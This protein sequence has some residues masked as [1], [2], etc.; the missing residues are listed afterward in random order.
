[1]GPVGF[2]AVSA[3]LAVASYNEQK[4]AAKAQQRAQKAKERMAAAQN[5]REKR[6]QLREARRQ[7]EMIAAEQAS[8]GTGAAAV[9]G[10]SSQAAGATVQ[11]ELGANL[12]F[13]DTMT[14]LNQYASEQEIYAS[15]K[16]TAATGYQTASDLVFSYGKNFA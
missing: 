6:K 14:G 11:Q 7:R 10:S 16:K 15:K 4:K 2:F 1:M 3:I 13:L 8:E 12:S 5:A 9:P